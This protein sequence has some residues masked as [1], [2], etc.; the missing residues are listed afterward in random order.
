MATNNLE[1]L[2]YIDKILTTYISQGALEFNF[3]PNKNLK[4]TVNNNTVENNQL[5][6]NQELIKVVVKKLIS[7]NQNRSIDS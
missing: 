7:Y 3:E 1:Y 5:P 4:I 2:S 6:L